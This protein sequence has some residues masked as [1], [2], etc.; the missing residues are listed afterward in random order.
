[1]LNINEIKNTIIKGDSLDVIKEIPDNSIDSIITSP[2]YFA[3][4]DYEDIRSDSDDGNLL[5]N[6]NRYL[7]ELILPLFKSCERIIKPGGHLWI[8][9]DDKHTSIKSEIEKNIV[10]PTHAYLIVELSKIYDYKEMVLWRKVR[11]K[12]SSGGS[13]R[14]LGSYGRF[15]SP[16]SIPI[17]QE[18]E[19]I[20]WFKK[21][22]DRTDI[23]DDRRKESALEKEEFADWGMQI[24]DIQPER[25]KKIGHPAP[26]PLELAHRMIKLSSFVGDIIL[27]PFIGSGSSAIS[28]FKNKRNYI[29][30][31]KDE[32][33]FELAKKRISNETVSLFD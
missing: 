14:M 16:G 3:D 24:W 25:A 10:L 17:V 29:G 18:V 5:N 13:L 15:R 23:N 12:S 6:Y 30:I 1:M 21:R 22:G 28:A 8:N 2:P 32:R 20:L 7:N 11:G 27:D 4:K 26:Y 31:E 9:I 33:Y 19:Y